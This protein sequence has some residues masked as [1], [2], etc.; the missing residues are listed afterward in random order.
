MRSEGRDID[1]S[2][3]MDRWTLQMGYPVVTVS[4]NQSEELLPTH[5]VTVTQDHFLYRQEVGSNSRQGGLGFG[6]GDVAYL[7]LMS[8]DHLFHGGARRG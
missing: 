4:R 6:G 3:V 5:V 2:S 8:C 1:V 7:L